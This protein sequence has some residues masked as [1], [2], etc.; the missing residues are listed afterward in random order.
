MAGNGGFGKLDMGKAWNDAVALLSTNR[1]VILIVAGVFFFLPNA[2][3]ALAIPE[4]TEL[5]AMTASG[6]QPDFEALSGVMMSYYAQHWWIFVLFGLV[7]A[8][9]MLGL[10]ALLTDTSRPTVGEAL[11]FGAKALLPYLGTQILLSLIVVAVVGIMIA[12]GS[13]IGPAVAVLLGLVGVV[14]MIYLLI[15]FSL[16]SPVIAIDKVM[17]PVRVLQ[18]S[19]QMTKGN[20]L[21]L[22]A[23]YF[24]LLLVLAVIT[25]VAGMV[26]AIFGIMGEQVG[27]FATA[28]GGAIISMAMTTV[29]LAVLAAVHRQ[30]SGGS[31]EAVRETFD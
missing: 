9:G 1:D 7:Q 30:L 21:R 13:L 2:I 19:W 24:L 23:F 5:E 27:L 10:L 22:L 6:A 8:I 20:S 16:I 25:I 28:I 29:M 4:P 15:K 14:V 31:A 26:F 18:R 3:S 11:A 12:I 17:N